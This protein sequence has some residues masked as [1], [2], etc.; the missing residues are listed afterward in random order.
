[1]ILSD[2][3]SEGSMK[4]QRESSAARTGFSLIELLVVIAINGSLI[5]LLLPA[6]QK[7]REAARRMTC[8]NHLRQISLSFHNH[9]DQLLSFPSGG[10]E[11][12]TQPTYINGAPATG[13][14]QQ[15][16]WG[17][18]ILPFIDAENVWR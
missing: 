17:F 18:Q 8:Q 11:W 16:G 12:W 5:G 4:S 9:H 6:V 2:S 3:D 13:A 10:H 14:A 1:M 15:A 7:V